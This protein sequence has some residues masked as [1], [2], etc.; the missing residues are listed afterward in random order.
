MH[1]SIGLFAV[2]VMVLAFAGP[3]GAAIPRVISTQGR[4]TD[5]S[6]TTMQGPVSMTF[7]IYPA[8]GGTACF[9][10][11]QPVVP[12]N[13]GLFSVGVGGATS[14]GIA[15]ACDFRSAYEL[16]VQVGTDAEMTPRIS[17]DASPYAISATRVG[18][19]QADEV[20]GRIGV[21]TATPAATLHVVGDIRITGP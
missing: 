9:T 18:I 17:F 7:R 11:T 16:S 8:G 19:L 15:A 20:N 12:L 5:A 4:L 2:G 21:G 3:V 14:G 13:G 6:G 1:K 10:E